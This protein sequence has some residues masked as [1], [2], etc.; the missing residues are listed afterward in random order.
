MRVIRTTN[1]LRHALKPIRH[2]GKKIALIPTM[3]ALHAGHMSLV[4][5]AH[6]LAECVVTS[7]FVNP[8]QFGPS[9]DLASYPR[10]EI[11]DLAKL[12]MQNV[13]IVYMPSVD[14][15]Y[16]AGFSTSISITGVSEGLCG[17]K[18]AGHFDGV[19]LVVTKLLLQTMPDIA[20]FGEKD[21]Q[22]LLVIK[23]LVSD[24]N[25]PVEIV[26]APIHREKDQLA[27]SSRN[28]YLTP[29]ERKIAPCL[30]QQLQHIAGH[31]A[32][33]GIGNLEKLIAVSTD[34]L[35]EKGFNHIDY[36]ELRDSNL[37]TITSSTRSARLLAAAFLGK[38]RLIDNVPVILK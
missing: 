21:Y 1:E 18:R 16:G 15:M 12:S 28:I 9:E 37:Q 38:C 17:G 6:N 20:I 19:A 27:M 36:I 29:E 11:E 14:E 34:Y 5:M 3:G 22:Q 10:P 35:Q 24:L 23:R 4:K 2:D 8:K 30:Y 31:I 26:A 25:I 32:T 7:I 33:D 13:D